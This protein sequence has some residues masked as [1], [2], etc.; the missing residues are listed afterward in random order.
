MHNRANLGFVA[1]CLVATLW[2]ETRIRAELPSP[3][4]AVA[5]SAA[6]WWALAVLGAALSAAAALVF[7]RRKGS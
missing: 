2:V 3:D 5:L 1:L 4:D 7:R 6:P